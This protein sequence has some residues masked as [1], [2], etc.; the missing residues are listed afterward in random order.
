MNEHTPT[1]INIKCN[2]EFFEMLLIKCH[3]SNALLHNIH[4]V[5]RKHE[6]AFLEFMITRGML[7]NVNICMS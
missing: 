1:L 4:L 6:N 7:Y 5:F 2:W 3:I